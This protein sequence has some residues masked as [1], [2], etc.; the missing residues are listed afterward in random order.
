M[1]DNKARC[2]FI[3]RVTVF[4]ATVVFANSVVMLIENRFDYLDFLKTLGVSL[5]IGVSLSSVI[6]IIKREWQ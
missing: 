2:P 4:T 5:L 6:S 1:A 3:Q